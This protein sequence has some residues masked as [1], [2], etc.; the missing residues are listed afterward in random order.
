MRENKRINTMIK[1]MH[2]VFA[3]AALLTA[4]SCAGDNQVF[5]GDWQEEFNIAGRQLTHTGKSKYFILTPGFQA[6]LESQE[7]KITITVLHETKKIGGIITRVVEERELKKGHLSEI[8]RNYFAMDAKTGD[9]FYFG[10]DVDNYE[11]GKIV[12]HAGTWKA[13][14]RGNK[15]GLIMPG[16]PRV[17]MKYYM[18]VAPGI[19]MDRAEVVSISEPLKTPAGDF[20]NCLKVRESSKIERAAKEYKTYAPGI[21]VA[22]KDELKLTRYGYLKRKSAK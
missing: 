9:V 8:S 21:G 6:V 16:N 15:P 14:E 7:D 22:Q 13:F 17:G 20:R 1:K 4:L 10:E 12:D 18:E 5:A 2:R 3:A 11:K 19:A